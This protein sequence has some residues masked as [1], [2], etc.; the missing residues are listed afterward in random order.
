MTIKK[1][2]EKQLSNLFL[3]AK[4]HT[5][6]LNHLH[7]DYTE[8]TALMSNDNFVT[9]T[10]ILNRY[11]KED[12]NPRMRSSDLETG[13]KKSVL[14]SEVN[15]EN[16]Q[17]VDEIFD[18]LNFRAGLFANQYPFEATQNKIILKNDLTDIQ[19]LYLILL[20]SSNLNYFNLVQPELT[21]EFESISYH[22]LKTVLPSNGKIKEFG[23]NS[24]YRGTAKNKIIELAKDLNVEIVEKEIENI[25]GNKEDGLDLIAWIPFEDKIPNMIT[26]MGQCAC[27]KDWPEKQYET[28]KFYDAYYI[29]FRLRPIRS[30]FIPYALS[31]VSYTFYQTNKI[32][33]TLLFDRKRILDNIKDTEF[34]NELK[35]KIIV[36]KCIKFE[37][38]IV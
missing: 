32:N 15:D 12:I 21:T 3:E 18:I 17:W 26:I 22:A 11:K 35:A 13:R 10:D 31:K 28:D 7:A 8:L 14:N 1:K 5:N 4:K 33:Q 23:N 19:K 20:L 24:D 37:E 25:L 9:T 29:F 36:E 30:L 34:L 27:G 6:N 2:I 38:D 16:E